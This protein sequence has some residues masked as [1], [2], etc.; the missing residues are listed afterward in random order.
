MPPTV[1][2]SL[3]WGYVDVS[4]QPTMSR[5]LKGFRGLHFSL[6]KMHKATDIFMKLDQ[7]KQQHWAAFDRK[8]SRRRLAKMA[9]L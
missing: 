1:V 2:P 3:L 4:S 7:G 6:T 5:R 9:G 8:Q